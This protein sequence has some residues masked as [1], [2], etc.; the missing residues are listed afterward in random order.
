MIEDIA[1]GEDGLSVR[2]KLNELIGTVNNLYEVVTGDNY[3][4]KK[5]INEGGAFS[6]QLKYKLGYN[7]SFELDLFDVANAQVYFSELIDTI[8]EVNGFDGDT[9]DWTID[10]YFRDQMSGDTRYY[11]G[12]TLALGGNKRGISQAFISYPSWGEVY[13]GDT[14]ARLID[15]ML[16]PV[17]ITVNSTVASDI[18]N[19]LRHQIRVL[20]IKGYYINN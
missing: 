11:A 13:T 10:R 1:N 7:T 20:T 15:L 14:G 3:T 9:G 18:G 12:L 5:R 19:P 16:A 4:L 6:I 2:N 8:S 17:K